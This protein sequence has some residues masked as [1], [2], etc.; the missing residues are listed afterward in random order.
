MPDEDGISAQANNVVVVHDG[1]N[2]YVFTTNGQVHVRT[3][4]LA[5]PHVGMCLSLPIE[6]E[7]L[8]EFA[9]RQ[10]AEARAAIVAKCADPDGSCGYCAKE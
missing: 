9:D 7:T 3:V 8:D 10:A 1:E 5:W 6:G 2:V 4:N